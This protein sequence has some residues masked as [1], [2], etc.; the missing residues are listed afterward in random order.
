MPDHAAT[1]ARPFRHAPR[2]RAA[3]T[4][5]LACRLGVPL[6]AVLLVLAAAGA[7]AQP[8]PGDP[9]LAAVDSLLGGHLARIDSSGK[10]HVIAR[11]TAGYPS[12]VTMARDNT[13][14]LCA[15]GT[16][17]F[18]ILRVTPAGL[19]T[20]VVKMAQPAQALALDEHGRLL[21]VAGA[22]RSRIFAVDL[23]LGVVTTLFADAAA[24]APGGALHLDHGDVHFARRSPSPALLRFHPRTAALTTLSTA[25]GGTATGLAWDP[26]TGDT[27]VTTSGP[28]GGVFSADAGGAITTLFAAP[29]ARGVRVD[30]HDLLWVLTSQGASNRIERRDRA[31][32]VLRTASHLALGGVTGFTLYA[33]RPL[34]GRGPAREGTTYDL[35]LS[36]PGGTKSTWVLGASLGTRPALRLPDGRSIRLY[37]DALFLNSINGHWPGFRNFTGIL[38]AAGRGK[39]SVYLPTGLKGLRVFFAGIRLDKQAPAMVGTVLNPVGMTVQ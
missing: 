14:L 24:P 10:S 17:P 21:A 23:D 33:D 3:R 28:G 18:P 2:P 13:D 27:L 11:F 29:Y 32:K 34:H 38:D 9:I 39:A 8:Q 15:L 19:V 12:A 31:G 26:A 20:T 16:A 5:G 1:A 7:T 35:H 37:P 22:T 4:A 36:V 30:E 25:I 6:A